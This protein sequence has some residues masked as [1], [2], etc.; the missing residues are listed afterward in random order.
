MA[1]KVKRIVLWRGVVPNVPGSLARTLAP[2]AGGNLQIVMGYHLHG[3]RDEAIVEVYPVSGKKATAAA[4]GMGL[5][6]AALPALLVQGDDRPG[7]GHATADALGRAGININFLV[8]QVVRKQYS[9]VFGF[10]SEAD[11]TSA[12]ALIKKAAATLQRKKGRR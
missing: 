4:A 3:G 10:S 8:A 2:L 7:L 5:A 12:A 11:A 6:G 9:A 1:V